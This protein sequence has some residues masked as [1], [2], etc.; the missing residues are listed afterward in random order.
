MNDINQQ[1][2]LVKAEIEDT[3]LLVNRTPFDLL[4]RD[5]GFS[6][7]FQF[8]VTTLNPGL[9]RYADNSIIGLRFDDATQVLYFF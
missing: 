8:I 5:D 2:S 6:P 9:L 4:D 7:C 1:L 3:I